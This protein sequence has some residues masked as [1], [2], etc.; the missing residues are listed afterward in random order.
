MP[1]KQ[2]SSQETISQ[3][4][5]RLIISVVLKSMA[6]WAKNFK[7]GFGILHAVSVRVMN[8][9]NLR[10]S[11]VSTAGANFKSASSFEPSANRRVVCWVLRAYHQATANPIANRELEYLAWRAEKFLS[12]YDAFQANRSTALKRFVVTLSRAIFS[13]RAAKADYL[14]WR[15]ADSASLFNSFIFKF[16]VI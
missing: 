8:Y 13:C 16:E 14:E 15:I 1:L 6:V 2:G 7:V 9:E 3:N 10:M 5:A 11:I 4:I 12:A